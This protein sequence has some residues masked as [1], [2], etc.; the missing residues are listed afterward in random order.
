MSLDAEALSNTMI[1]AAR[2]AVAERWPAVKALAE[3]ELRRL[4][5][6]LIE[7]K[8][9]V[10]SGRI[11]QPGAQKLI[12]IHQMTVRSVLLTVK[13]IGLATAERVTFVA[14]EAVTG[15]VNEV[16]GFKLL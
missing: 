4:A 5:Q 10:A 2:D 13:G 3:V 16:V 15:I 6:S 7:I 14:V 1:L 9:L 12:Q 11:D 8:G